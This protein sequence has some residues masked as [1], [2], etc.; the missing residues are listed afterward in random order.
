[1]AGNEI[2]L[3]IETCVDGHGPIATGSGG[4]GRSRAL[5]LGQNA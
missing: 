3:K 2:L 1:M 4:T 5:L